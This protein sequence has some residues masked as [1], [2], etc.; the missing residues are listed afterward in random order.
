MAADNAQHIHELLVTRAERAAQRII[1][2]QSRVHLLESELRESDEDLSYLRLGLKAIE[3]Q[4]PRDVLARDTEL[5]R[6]IANWKHDYADL[7]KK[8]TAR[9]R[10]ALGDDSPRTADG[11]QNLMLADSSAY[12][13]S[14]DGDQSNALSTPSRPPPSGG[15][16]VS[17]NGDSI[18]ETPSPRASRI[19]RTDANSHLATPE[20]FHTM[21]SD[22]LYENEETLTPTSAR[23]QATAA[24][25]RDSPRVR[26]SQRPLSSTTSSKALRRIIMSATPPRKPRLV[27]LASFGP[28]LDGDPDRARAAQ[29]HQQHQQHH[30]LR[31]YESLR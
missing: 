23:S 12:S 27:S 6:S 29:Q 3:V 24:S 21:S 13:E 14:A 2:L 19:R 9:R 26:G 20:Y 10:R 18:F 31:S 1:F 11:G 5:A 15:S 30:H 22:D 17:S 16:Y 25:T 7:K 8:R 4:C 28:P